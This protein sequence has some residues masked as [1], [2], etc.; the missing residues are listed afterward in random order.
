MKKKIAVIFGS[1]SSEHEISCLSAYN[2]IKHLDKEKY[3][4]DTIGIDKKGMFFK[5]TGDIENIG[6]N[7]WILDE[8][9]KIKIEDIIA[10]LK[11]YDVVFP[12][13]HGKYGEDG[14][15]QGMLE[16]AKVKYVGCNNLGSSIAIN[17]ILSKELV[18]SLGI[19]VVPYKTL[20]IN[21]YLKMD[22]KLKQ[23]LI[24]EI[25]NKIKFPLIIKPNKEGSSY[26]VSKVDNVDNLIEKIEYVF[27]FD[28]EIII[29]K[30]ISNRHEVECAVL[31]MLDGTLLSSIPGEVISANEF[32]DFNAKYENKSSYTKIPAQCS[33]EVL[34]KIK[35]YSLKIFK[36]LRLTS[37]SRVDFFV[38]HDKIYFNEVNT[39]PGF[40]N[41]SMYPMLISYDG[42]GYEK[43]LDIL[44]QNA[45]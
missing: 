11:T 17:K 41:I 20:K 23:K 37:L 2:I 30:Y 1:M 12:V 14:T 6:K 27:R 15:L 19:L 38:S 42:I 4:V 16:F 24:E 43:L 32:Y 5:Y 8:K 21:E 35:K 40:T 44:I 36:K 9:N 22:I 25:K 13:L 3:N 26:G 28:E 39:F 45:K 18:E 31:E 33:K 34:E 29:E 10:K 7:K